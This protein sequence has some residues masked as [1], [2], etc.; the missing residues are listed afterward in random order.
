[1]RTRFPDICCSLPVSSE[2]GSP[3]SNCHKR[4]RMRLCPPDAPASSAFRSCAPMAWAA[5][6]SSPRVILSVY[7]PRRIC[8]LP[9]VPIVRPAMLLFR[10]KIKRIKHSSLFSLLFSLNEA[11]RSSLLPTPYSLTSAPHSI[12]PPTA[13]S[14]ARP[15]WLP[16][17]P[18]SRPRSSG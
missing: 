18:R 1:M 7:G 8:C 14:A 5:L 15:R 6:S 16:C 2:Y 3:V 17:R 9:C 4:C 11:K 13:R 10:K 12:R